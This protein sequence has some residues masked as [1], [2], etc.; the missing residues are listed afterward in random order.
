MANEI[1][2]SWLH[3]CWN[4]QKFLEIKTYNIR[5][6]KTPTIQLLNNYKQESKREKMITDLVHW[7]SNIYINE[8]KK[9]YMKISYVNLTYSI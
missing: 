4:K 7:V 8:T 3:K 1:I 5:Y 9:K 6:F 2:K